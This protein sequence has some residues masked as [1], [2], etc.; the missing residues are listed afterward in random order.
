MKLLQVIF[1]LFCFFPYTPPIMSTDSQPCAFG[2]A[3]LLHLFYT[4]RRCPDL[5]LLLIVLIFSFLILCFSPLDFNSLRSI[6]NY[7]SLF[8]VCSATYLVLKN[9]EL[10]WHLFKCVVYI[11]F[12]VGLIQMF[13]IPDFLSFLVPRGSAFLSGRGV[14]CLTPEPTFYAMIC[15]CLMVISFLN[16]R[17]H[18]GFYKINILLLVQIVCFAR[19]AT[20]I[21]IM[22]VSFLLYIIFSRGLKT[23]AAICFIGCLLYWGIKV[24]QPVLASYRAGHLFYS[25]LENPAEFLMIDESVNERFIHAFFPIYGFCENF[26]LP[27]GFGSFNAYMRDIYNR[28][29]FS[30][31]LLFYRDDYVRIMSGLGSAIFELGIVGC[32]IPWVLIKNMWKIIKEDKRFMFYGFLFFLILLNAMPLSNAIIGFVFGNIIYL[33]SSRLPKARINP[34]SN[35]RK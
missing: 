19:S 22:L 29:D 3:I 7:L 26:G 20:V 13:F 34:V 25:L 31:Y 32:L 33:G 11:Y 8:V 18:K 35:N 4:N 17:E 2:V 23:I 28:G 14:S 21:F 10:S 6:F 27:Y 12:F 15:T 1:L 9:K 16:F 30:T 24:L 5:F